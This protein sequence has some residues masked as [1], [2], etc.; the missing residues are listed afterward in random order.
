M[1]DV[2][3]VSPPL[4]G[5]AAD[6][7]PAVRPAPRR[8]ARPAPLPE[9]RV[10]LSAAAGWILAGVATGLGAP[11]PE[12]AARSVPAGLVVGL[13]ALL[14]T[15][16]AL[17]VGHQFLGLSARPADLAAGLAEGFVRSGRFAAG[18]AP[19]LAFFALTTSLWLPAAAL[20]GALAAIVALGRATAGLRRAEAPSAR[21]DG[22]VL[23]WGAL[24]SLVT[25]RLALDVARAV[26][27]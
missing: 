4:V 1:D 3:L 11:A 27:G 5:V 19:F 22:L 8:A 13:G 14:L 9:G 24:A 12:I 25:L 2:V 6:G 21:M 10:L 16:P 18:F 20:V 7:P 26:L 15:G 23:A 17:V